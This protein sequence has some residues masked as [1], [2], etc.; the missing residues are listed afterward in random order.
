VLKHTHPIQPDLH[1]L[2]SIFS[3]RREEGSPNPPNS[4]IQQF[5]PN[6][7]VD[8]VEVGR[9]FGVGFVVEGAEAVEA[10]PE[11]LWREEG[12]GCVVGGEGQ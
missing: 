4:L 3:R 6:K 7:R 12:E 11:G 2:F 5:G 1:P 9:P 10:R 8:E